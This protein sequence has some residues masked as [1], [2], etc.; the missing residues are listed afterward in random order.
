MTASLFHEYA[1]Y[2]FHHIPKHS[3]IL[4]YDLKNI[5]KENI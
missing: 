4:L 2:N 5:E 3:Y 1:F